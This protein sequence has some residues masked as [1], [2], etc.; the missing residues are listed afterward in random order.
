MARASPV[1]ITLCQSHIWDISVFCYTK[2]SLLWDRAGPPRAD[3]G[4]SSG[5]CGWGF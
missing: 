3:L 1:P 4:G 5:S 2:R